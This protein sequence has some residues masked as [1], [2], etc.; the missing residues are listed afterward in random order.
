MEITQTG[1]SGGSL[2][3]AN[4]EASSLIRVLLELP[5]LPAAGLTE[6]EGEIRE[7]ELG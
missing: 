5:I 7:I 6:P 1:G 2:T 4:A 3:E